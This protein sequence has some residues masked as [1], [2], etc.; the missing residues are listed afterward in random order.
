MSKPVEAGPMDRVGDAIKEQAIWT[1]NFGTR[2]I[3]GYISGFEGRAWVAQPFAGAN[4]ALWQIGHLAIATHGIGGYLGAMGDIPSTYEEL[5]G[6]GSAPKSDLAAYP[7]PE[8]VLSLWRDLRARFIDVVRQFPGER[9]HDTLKDEGMLR[10]GA[11]IIGFMPIHDAT[12]AGEL[13]MLRKHLGMAR[14]FG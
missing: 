4:H 13:A 6:M 5:F 14:V 11:E 3:E 8:S 2:Q 9:L 10:T 7:D 1:L 12:H